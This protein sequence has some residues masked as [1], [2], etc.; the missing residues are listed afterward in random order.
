MEERPR[1]AGASGLVVHV[2]EYPSTFV[3]DRL[4]P[5]D[6]AA[7]HFGYENVLTRASFY[8]GLQTKFSHRPWLVPWSMVPAGDAISVSRLNGCFGVFRRDALFEVGLFDPRLFLYFEEDDL[9]RRLTGRGYKLYV[10]SRTVVVHRAGTG[11]VATRSRTTELILLNSQY[12]FFR[13]HYGRGY[14]WAAFFAIWAVITVG[15]AYRALVR[16]GR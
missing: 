11:R 8:S 12:L 9:A 10:T 15:V 7:V 2:R 5:R 1:A 13:K 3:R 4:F 14:T 6:Q 16:G